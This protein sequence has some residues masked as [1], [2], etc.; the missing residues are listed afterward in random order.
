MLYTQVYIVN[1]AHLNC[2][3]GVITCFHFG[4]GTPY[5]VQLL[6]LRYTLF[7]LHV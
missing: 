6:V 4:K 2:T 1:V 3:N 5:S 7:L